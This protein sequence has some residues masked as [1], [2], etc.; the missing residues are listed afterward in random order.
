MDLKNR[1]IGMENTRAL[2]VNSTVLSLLIVSS[3]SSGA[4]PGTDVGHHV[5]KLHS[6]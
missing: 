6:I 4:L 3:S 5:T 1:G 2:V